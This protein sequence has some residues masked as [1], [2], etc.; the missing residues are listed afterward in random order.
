ERSRG[1]HRIALGAAA[2]GG[3]PMSKPERAPGEALD[4]MR[5]AIDRIDAELLSTLARRLSLC[6]E[7]AELKRTH[8]IPMMQPARVEL[9]LARRAAPA[10]RHGLRPEFVGRLYMLIIEEACRL[11][12]E[13]I[14]APE[15]AS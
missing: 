8:G 14:E 6:A 5:R 15:Q 13:I 3:E 1:P 2:R 12:D 11:E 10:P 7:V 4:E 9:V